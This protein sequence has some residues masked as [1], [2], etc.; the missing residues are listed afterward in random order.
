MEYKSKNIFLEVAIIGMIVLMLILMGL[1]I[2]KAPKK[3]L[4]NFKHVGINLWDAEPDGLNVLED[5]NTHEL[6]L[7][8]SDGTRRYKWLDENGKVRKVKNEK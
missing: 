6:W 8:T 4:T 2:K 1:S 5:V 7:E 3:E